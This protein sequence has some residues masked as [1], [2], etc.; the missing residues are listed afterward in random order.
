M[1]DR[2]TLA[3]RLTEAGLIEAR[4][5]PVKDGTKASQVRHN[6]ASNRE[7]SFASLS[8]N[9]GVYAGANPSGDR[10]LIDVDIDDYSESADSDALEAVNNLPD[11]LTVKSPHTDGDTGGHRYYYVDGKDVHKSIEAV[12]GAMNP[13]P[14]WGEIR[15]HN[16]YVV[17]PASQLDGC[18]KEWCDNCSKPD[19]GYYEIATDAPIAEISLADLFEVI[20]ADESGKDTSRATE[21]VDTSGGTP[22]TDGDVSH[23]EAVAEHYQNIKDYLLYGSGDRSESDFH[24]CCRMIEH[25]VSESEAYRL[26]ANNSNSKVDS[27]DASDNY[28]QLT[29]KRAKRQVGDDAGSKSLP[30]TDGGTM[31]T[32][33]GTT[34]TTQTNTD[35]P[36]WDTVYRQYDGASEADERKPARYEAT[37]LLSETHHWANLEENDVLYAYG[38]DTGIYNPTGEEKVRELLVNNLR[39]QYAKNEKNEILD[40]LRG[41]HTVSQE[42][43]GGPANHIPVRNGVLEV[44]THGIELKDHAPEYRFLGSVATEYDPNADCPQFREF[45]SD[46]VQSEAQRKKLQEYA[47]YTLMHWGLP[48]HKALFLVGPT[49]SGKSTFLDTVRAVLGSD[50]VVSL[51]PQELTGER[52]AGAELFQSWANFRNDIPSSLIEDTGAFK[53]I[54]AGDSIKAEEKFKDPFRF[55]PNAKHLFSAN[56][57]PDAETEDEAFYRRVLLVP[58]PSTVP[59]AERD[60]HLDEKLQSE[61]SGVLNW[62]LEGL[63]RLMQ[64]GQFTA[65]RTPGETQR[66]WEKWGNTV[67]RFREICLEKSEDGEL[68]KKQAY[69]AYHAFCEAESLPAET[70][71]KMTRRLKSEGIADGRATVNGKQQ[72]VFVGVQLT[73]KGESYLPDTSDEPQESGLRHFD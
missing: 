38:S 8:G 13:G 51:T 4:L 42:D 64:Q 25:G 61:L 11:T 56:Q 62:M 7:S 37:K 1:S 71:H 30:T 58:F 24:V 35:T 41:R 44:Q 34:D 5:I 2:E 29:W 36:T 43:M 57:L 47:G 69:H 12:A 10:W 9:Y 19:G 48:Y 63:Q 45:L 23:A 70:Q 33:A 28:W 27:N 18:D 65:D 50:T 20:R 73:G 60:P 54:T 16:Q 14:S 46:V 66:T 26:L 52:F 67:D 15:V 21:S 6:D 31:T 17:G 22:N 72:R 3:R 40:Q 32:E 59:K 39:E 53:E 55:E 68:P 49:A